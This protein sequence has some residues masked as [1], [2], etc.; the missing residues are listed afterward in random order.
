MWASFLLKMNRNGIQ[1]LL[2]QLH[3]S[4]EQRLLALNHLSGK[5]SLKRFPP[6]EEKLTASC[7]G[8][9]V[10]TRHFSFSQNSWEG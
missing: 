5:M 1:A 4:P 9:A 7:F 6:L 2:R 10:W 8:Q 3:L